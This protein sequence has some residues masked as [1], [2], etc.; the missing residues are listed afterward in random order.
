M[1]IRYAV[2]L[3]IFAGFGFGALAVQ[4]LHAQAG[5]PVYAVAEIDYHR[6]GRVFDLCPQGSDR[7]QGGR[8]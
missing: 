2:A 4:G 1:K 5:P 8:R 3:S 7:D 6:S